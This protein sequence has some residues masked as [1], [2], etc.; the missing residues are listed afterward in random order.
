MQ[1]TFAII[2]SPQSNQYLHQIVDSIEQ[3]NIPDR[4]YEI[5]QVGADPID[6]KNL[7]HIPFDENIKAGWITRKKN[8][9]AQNA[10][11]QNISLLHDYIVFDSQWYKNFQKFG[12]F[13]DICMNRVEDKF[14]KRYRD[15]LS[16][17]PLEFLP[18]EVENQT[19]RM[20]FSGTFINIK[21]DY[22]LLHPFNEHL[23]WGMAEDI[24][25][26]FRMRNSGWNYRMNPQSIVRLLKDHKCF[27]KSPEE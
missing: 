9:A 27:P 10:K 13:W 4:D 3:Q 6:R 24:E 14:G 20:Y 2:T 26:S 15:W 22:L 5:I 17:E 18:Y 23:T 19:H 16:F 25:I 11:F 21:R 12:D 8:L 1:W 7:K